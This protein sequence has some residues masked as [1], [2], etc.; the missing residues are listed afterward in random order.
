MLCEFVRFSVTQGAG[1]H[2]LT[3]A[4]CLGVNA[5]DA[6]AASVTEAASTGS[7]IGVLPQIEIFAG[8]AVPVIGVFVG[9]AKTGGA[10]TS[11]DGKA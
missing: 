2:S 4:G 9:C 5:W 10:D 8:A 7:I 3:T 6:A 11:T 1:T